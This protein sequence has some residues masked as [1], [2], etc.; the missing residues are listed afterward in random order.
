M[1]LAKSGLKQLFGF[2]NEQAIV[3]ANNVSLSLTKSRSV[4]RQGVANGGRHTE[5][6]LNV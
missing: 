3:L 1:R 5:W 2:R 4:R 6:W